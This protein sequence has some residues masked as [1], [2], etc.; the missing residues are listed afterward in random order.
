[1]PSEPSNHLNRR[2]VLVGAAAS[3]AAMA[4]PSFAQTLAAGPM[5]GDRVFLT[6]EDSN[7]L[8]VID[9]VKDEVMAT[10]NLTSFDEDARPPFRFV[11]GGVMP[12]H[13]DM[14]QKPL[15]HGAISVHG[16]APSPDSRIFATAG[17]GTSNLYL[18]DA[19]SLKVIGNTANP[20]AGPTTNPEL[21][22]S[23]LLI[24][25]EP[26]EPTFTRN[27]REIWV[28]LRGEN[29]LAVID[30]QKAK[31]E[32][33][34]TVPR[35]ASIRAFVP[36]M[37][38]P[39]MVWFSAKGDLAFIISQKTPRMDVF[40]VSYNS[41]GLSTAERKATIDTAAQ[42]KFGFAPFLK[43][44]PDGREMW[45]SQKLADTVSVFDASGEH[46]L[47][48]TLP[49]GE[50][51]RPNH[52]E[53]VSNAKGSVAYATFAR[54]DDGGPDGVA[55]SKIAIIDRSAPAGQRKVIGAFASRGRE[56]HGIWTD[57]SNSKLYVAHE[58]DE[59][60]N[61]PNAG[62]TVCTVFDVTDPMAPRFIKQI[63]LGTCDFPSGKLRNKKS[64]NLVYVRPG[65]PSATA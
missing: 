20:Q 11:T 36:T 64:I 2:E 59:M 56:A 47:V 6:N 43:L 5:A 50:R 7:T 31:A 42:D 38:G 33:L 4:M 40:R 44:T 53:F 24:G 23:G 58:L 19:T 35:G 54:V 25:R 8:S 1:M 51:A 16:C 57:P 60:P 55:S 37:P 27:G 29:R 65:A 28:A 61:T 62:Q 39:A 45:V 17:R 22:T 10:I 26:H 52:V 34:G 13:A 14:I 46:G 12:T 18:I 9:P 3:V 48:D 15:Y 63:P 32:L 30:V 21:L 49:L 41:E